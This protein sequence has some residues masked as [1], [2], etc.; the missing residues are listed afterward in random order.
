[1]NG[2][3]IALSGFYLQVLWSILDG[4]VQD[5]W[6][7]MT[8]EP[9]EADMEQ[10]DIR[11]TLPG[12]VRLDQVKSTRRTFSMSKVEAWASTLAQ[13]KEAGSSLRLVLLGVPAGD[14]S[15]RF[16]VGG[17]EVRLTTSDDVLLRDAATFR[18]EAFLR[19]QGF[20][21]PY[22]RTGELL[23]ALHGLLL[24]RARH[25]FRWS[26]STLCA[27]IRDWARMYNLLQEVVGT[28]A[29]VRAERVQA[30]MRLHGMMRAKERKSE[31]AVLLFRSC[32]WLPPP[33]ADPDGYFEVA[34][35]TRR[36]P[37]ESEATGASLVDCIPV[38]SAAVELTY[39]WR[40]QGYSSVMPAIIL[41]PGDCTFVSGER[42][43]D[44]HGPLACGP[45]GAEVA[46]LR[47]SRHELLDVRCL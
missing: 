29:E 7:E 30:A 43:N 14:L 38:L 16:S 6:T 1:M 47:S 28:S 34:V 20:R 23:E 15:S 19:D 44:R 31:G 11:W 5:D 46:V 42:Y 26:R 33:Y 37:G 3:Q 18:L 21:P 36:G 8:I 9:A 39:L 45:M 41:Q 24:V 25:G 13:G 40:F 4:V 12:S 32:E 2:G 35:R 27:V 17:V 10:V 22:G